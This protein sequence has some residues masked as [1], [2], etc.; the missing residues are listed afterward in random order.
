M[1]RKLRGDADMSRRLWR[2]LT[3]VATDIYGEIIHSSTKESPDFLWYG[4]RRKIS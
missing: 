2:C 1:D 3:Q 4:I